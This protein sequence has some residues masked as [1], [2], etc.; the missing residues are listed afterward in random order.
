MTVSPMAS[1]A[2]VVSLGRVAVV[3]VARDIVR[4]VDLIARDKLE[5]IRAI[6]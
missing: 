6:V 5:V 4:D 1:R 3:G 2:R